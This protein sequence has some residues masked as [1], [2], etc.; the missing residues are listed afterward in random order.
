MCILDDDGNRIHAKYYDKNVLTTVKEQN[1]FE[2]TLFNETHRAASN[3]IRLNDLTIVYIRNDDL[4]FY[5]V[6]DARE[7]TDEPVLSSVLNRLYDS[8]SLI[9]QEN[10]EKSVA[11]DHLDMISLAFDEICDDG[12]V[13][14]PDLL[15]FHVISVE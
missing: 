11:L 7:Q 6:G 3:T 13:S 5:V 15:M 4:I 9:L 8:I 2:K 1:A 12:Y 14:M 10:V